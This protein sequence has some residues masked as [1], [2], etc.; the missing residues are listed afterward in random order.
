MK[1]LRQFGVALLLVASGLRPVMACSNPG[2]PMSAAERAC[3]QM[4]H[5]ECER[6]GMSASSGCCRKAPAGA[7]EYFV[8]TKIAGDHAA[9]VAT[10]G[11]A[12]ADS[13]AAAS[14]QT[15]W[16]EYANDSPPESPPTSVAILR[17]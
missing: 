11:L 1:L 15:G 4:M 8:E 14:V 16:V 2:V 17:I 7:H 12:V 6:M 10:L 3:C 13:C 9:P 5:N